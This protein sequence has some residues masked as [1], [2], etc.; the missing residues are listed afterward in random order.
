MTKPDLSKSE[1]AAV[2]AA[3]DFA[4]GYL[5]RNSQTWEQERWMPREM[6]QEAAKAGLC[7]LLVRPEQGGMGIG[8]SA[9]MKVMEELS[10][11]DMAAAFALVVHNNHVRFID[12]AGS[13]EQITRFLP[14]MLAG[15]SVG[16]F[17]LTEPQG[18]SDA[19]AIT[20]SALPDGRGYVL[21]GEKAWITNTPHADLLNVFAQTNPDAGSKGIASFQVPADT[22]GVTRLPAYDML[23]GYAIG[24]GGFRLE[25]VRVSEDALLVPAGQGFK[26]AMAGIDIARA[27]VAAMCVGLLRAGLDTAMPRLM[28]RHAFG[29]PLA[30]QQGL[31]WQMAD[32]STSLRA[33]TLLAY[34]AARLIERDGAAPE[35][36]AHAKKFATEAAFAGLHAC[37][38]A[39]GADG[40]KQEFPLARH[41]AAAKMAQYLDGTTEIQNVVISRALQK[42]YSG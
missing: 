30:G 33:C 10:Y 40:L 27:C 7:G 36:A 8:T 5:Q 38:Q 20:T 4:S 34:D 26:A 18:G 21:N 1:Q 32:V 25:D 35:A 14:K 31:Q 41:L 16:A 37:M 23:G 6:F 19:A 11:V 24:A 39:M 42:A 28:T 2:A 3:R 15:E 9:L 17:L 13:P 29:R 12:K 22:P